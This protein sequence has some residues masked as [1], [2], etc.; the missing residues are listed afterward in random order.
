MHDIAIIGAGI[1]GCA[2]SRVLSK[3]KLKTVL[4]EKEPDVANVTTKANSAI[5][6]A[7]YDAK[8]NTLKA[9]LNVL[10]NSMYEELCETLDVVFKR[11]GSL[12]LAF[13]DEQI[14]II[15]KLFVQGNKNGVKGLEIISKDRV[16]LIEPNISE[17]VK[18]ALYAPSC[19]IVGP[20]EIAI[21]MA[22]NA[23]DNGVEIRLNTKVEDI[24]RLEN[25][26]IIKTDKG[27]IHAQY[28]VNCAGLHADSINDMV[29]SHEYKIIPRRGEYNIA[30][31]SVGGL[32]NTVI[33]QCPSSLGKGVL[34]SPTV[35]GNLLIGPNSVDIEDKTGFHTTKEGL[36]YVFA[37]ASKSL[38]A[39]PKSSIIT[40]YSGLRARSNREDFIIE[41]AQDVPHFINVAGIESP[42]LTAAPAIATY[43]EKM[44]LKTGLEMI[45]KTD[46]IPNR[47]KVIRFNEMSNEER[48]ELIKKDSRFGKVICRCELVTEGEI[49]D[50]IHRN[51][52]ARNLDGVKR[53]A[54]PGSGRCQGG[55]CSPRVMEIIARELNI[56]IKSVVKDGKGS[57]I[58]TSTTKENVVY[59][60]D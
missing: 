17:N 22:E 5:V 13:D 50:A 59:N 28:V 29:S 1:V 48:Q 54:R 8:P 10:G 44:L 43:V 4:I 58:L 57:Y 3:Y 23:A 45:P 31:K 32:V 37:T 56:D 11:I 53:R 19:G 27:E 24:E 30:D 14:E 26:F 49:V 6:H 46:Y 39:L 34:I 9:E 52:G 21:A 20:W 60:N 51:P 36:D 42:G 41:E 33:F 16:K 18:K 25:G 47:R 38:E 40:Q 7:G 15:S 12:V 2:I 35:H 55:F